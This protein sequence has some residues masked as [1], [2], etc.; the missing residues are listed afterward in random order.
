MDW[1]ANGLKIKS[2]RRVCLHFEQV[3]SEI[4]ALERNDKIIGH[5]RTLSREKACA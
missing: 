4:S 1:G 3:V 5:M 2:L